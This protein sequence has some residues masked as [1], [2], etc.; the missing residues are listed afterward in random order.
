MQ[1]DDKE[2]PVLGV[3]GRDANKVFYVQEVLP[4]LMAG[5]V[6][7]LVSALR[8]ASY[9]ELLARAQIARGEGGTGLDIDVIMQ[10]LQGSD[11]LAVHALIKEALQHVHVAADP[12]HPGVRRPL[13]PDFS[14]IRE[15]KTLGDVLMAFVRLHFDLGAL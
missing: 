9:E 10:V 5:Y 1:T 7:R 12:Q 4:V 15:Q 11:P 8:V 14:D 6:L 2:T 3:H 13:L